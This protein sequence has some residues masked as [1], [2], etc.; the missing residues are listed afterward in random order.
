MF[1]RCIQSK[2]PRYEGWGCFLTTIVFG[3]I[4]I[5]LVVGVGG[6]LYHDC[7]HNDCSTQRDYGM[8]CDTYCWSDQ[9]GPGNG[10]VV[11]CAL[12]LLFALALPFCWNR[13]GRIPRSHYGNFGSKYE[14]INIQ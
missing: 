4:G 13:S 14:I 1:R 5:V 12:A 2:C 10:I 11:I 8:Y 9:I 7:E 6:P 3:L